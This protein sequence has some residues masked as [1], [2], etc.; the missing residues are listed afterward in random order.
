L[1]YKSVDGLQSREGTFLACTFWL[2]ECL[3]RQ[4]RRREALRAFKHATAAANDLGLFAEQYDS[5]SKQ[6]LGNFPQGLT[7]L[8]HIS[9]ALALDPKPKRRRPRRRE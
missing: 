8:A 1:R 5:R 4:G 3:A 6:M 9:A 2:V 7:H